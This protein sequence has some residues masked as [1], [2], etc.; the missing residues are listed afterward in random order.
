MAAVENETILH[1]SDLQLPNGVELTADLS[2]SAHDHP[3]VSVHAAKAVGSDS[4][5]EEAGEAEE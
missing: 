2:D 1:L 5:S 4:E 3:I